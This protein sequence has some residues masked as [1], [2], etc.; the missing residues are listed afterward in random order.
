MLDSFSGVVDTCVDRRAYLAAPLSHLEFSNRKIDKVDER[1][2]GWGFTTT[3]IGGDTER[4]RKS[5]DLGLADVFDT[6]NLPDHAHVAM[7]GGARY[8]EL[9]A[10]RIRRTPLSGMQLE[11]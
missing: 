5:Q 4:K 2:G 11:R 9:G 10:P 1:T 8:Q 7:S 6:S 3:V